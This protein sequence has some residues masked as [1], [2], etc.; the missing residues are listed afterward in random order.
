MNPKQMLFSSNSSAATD[1]Q[2]N[3]RAARMAQAADRFVQLLIR[4]Q[5]TGS[6]PAMACAYAPLR[7]SA[8]VMVAISLIVLVFGVLVPVE[9]AAIAKGTVAVMSKRKTVQH[10]EGGV[11]KS[12]LVKDGDVV[13]E[14]Q[15]LLEI[16]DVAPKANRSIVEADL[17]ME[18]AAEARLNA[19]RENKETLLFPDEIMQAAQVHADLAKTL[20]T[21]QELFTTQREAQLGKL[22][23]L[24]QRLAEAKEEITGL[25][26][27]I[28]SAEGQ[29]AYINEEIVTVQTL[30]KDGLSTRPRL[31]ALQRAAEELKGSRGQ[32]TAL[33]AK[34]Q[35]GMTETEMQIINQQNEFATQI[36]QELKEV[37]SQIS[38]HR[39]KLSAVADV[40]ERTVVTAPSEGI[41]TGLKYHTV[42]GVVEPGS[43]ILDIV[44]QQEQLVLEVK[45]QP[46]DIDVVKSGLESRVVFPAYRARRMPLLNGKVIQVSADA[47]TEKQGLGD[48]SYYTAK[49]EVDASQMKHMDIP[50]NLYPGMPADVY[51]NTGSRSFIAY[52]MAPVTDSMDRAFKEE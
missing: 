39:E 43:P 47:F 10:L 18:R 14:G 9:S 51:I 8:L 35:Q 38:D 17:W 41:V 13:K 1:A 6:N 30:L 33:I 4:K 40:M 21:Q 16:S 22:Q 19:L 12:I 49:V 45:I 52:L 20:K 15:P 48:V 36:A 46:T 7:A 26:A 42:G 23:S 2:A 29:L 50:V 32:N 25:R 28:R 5:Y 24:H 37:S 27:Q 3:D 11:I 31:L 34:V 44:P